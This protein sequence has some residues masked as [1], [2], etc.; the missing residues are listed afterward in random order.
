VAEDKDVIAY[1]GIDCSKCFSHKRTVSDS[2]RK[3]RRELRSANQKDLWKEVPFLGDYK[4]FKKTLDGLAMLR[5]SRMC[6]GGGGN[7]WCKIRSC[8]KGKGYWSCFEC[9]DVLTCAKLKPISK[10]RRNEN[11]KNLRR[12][13]GT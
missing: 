5:C 4:E 1:C 9:N 6:R 13:E 2:A 11:L 3:L 7:P 12:L 8:A 10:S